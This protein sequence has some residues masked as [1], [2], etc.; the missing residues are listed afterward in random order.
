ME[1][2][3]QPPRPTPKSFGWIYLISVV[4]TFHTLLTAYSSSTYMEQFISPEGVGLLYALGSALSILLFLTLAPILTRL[5][6]TRTTILFMMFAIT[7]LVCLGLQIA[8]L[9]A[10][11]LFMALNPL[12]YF[13]IDIFSENT[14]GEDEHETGSKRGLTLTLMSLAAVLAPLTMGLLV[15]ESSERLAYPYFVAAG[16]GSIFIGILFVRFRGFTDPHYP[17]VRLKAVFQSFIHNRNIRGVIGA[18]FLLQFFF[19]WVVIYFPLYLATEL[20]FEW[21]TIGNIIAV[22]LIAYVL[23]EYPVGVVA[24]RYIGEKE[25]MALGFV[26]IALSSASI[27]FLAGASVAA[28]MTVMFVSRIGA[29]LVEVT[30]ESYFFKQVHSGDAQLISLFRLTRPLANLTGAIAGSAALALLPFELMFVV[31]AFIMVPG[32]ILATSIIDTK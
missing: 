21:S 20:G 26:I 27:S 15:G 29:S 31:L 10:F 30:S 24:D 11:V 32:I 19:A 12:L 14:I 4:F 1:P 23:F 22:G 6:N 25:M 8:P 17:F 7:A 3:S 13:S 28:W 9:V 16:I 2:F 18:Q 5:G